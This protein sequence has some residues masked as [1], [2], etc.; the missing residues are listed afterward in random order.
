MNQA[1]DQIKAVIEQLESLQQ[2]EGV[3]KNVKTEIQSIIHTLRE[4]GEASMHINKCLDKLDHLSQ[5][6]TLEAFIR[7]QIWNIASMLEKIQ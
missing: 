6:T 7:P 3:P 5:E 4:P 1:Q 2:E